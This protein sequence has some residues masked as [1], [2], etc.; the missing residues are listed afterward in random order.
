MNAQS[1][2]NKEKEEDNEIER[3]SRCVPVLSEYAA[4]LE[5][6]VK[7]RY[8]KKISILGV[9]PGSISNEQFHGQ[10]VLQIEQSDLFC[11]LVLQSSYYTKEQYK[12]YK[13]LEAYNQVVSCRICDCSKRKNYF[14]QVCCSRKSSSSR[15]ITKMYEHPNKYFK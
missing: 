2:E 1:A 14:G 3:L 7:L 10:C 4:S 8:L 11:C 15:F 13:S 12:N 5:S 9:D 6:H